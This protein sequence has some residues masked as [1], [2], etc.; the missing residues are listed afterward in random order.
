MSK[1]GSS[2]KGNDFLEWWKHHYGTDYDN[3]GNITKSGSMTDED[4]AIGK[5]LL[6]S[7]NTQQHLKSQYNQNVQTE[8]DKYNDLIDISDR[9]YDSKIENAQNE[10]D[11]SAQLLLDNYNRNTE[12]AK[13]IYDKNTEELLANYGTA[14]SALD[15]S[16]RQSQQNASITL[17]KLK[18]YLPT[19]I[20]AQGLGGLGVSESSMLKAY[21][22]YNSDMGAIESG[23]QESKSDLDANYNTNKNAYDTQYQKTRGDLDAL[24]GESQANLE[25]GLASAKSGLETAKSQASDTYKA[26][27]ADTLAKL[28]QGYDSGVFNSDKDAQ[29]N[30]L[31]DNV[32][33]EYAQMLS[34]EQG[35]N[36]ETALNAI[37]S[38]LFSNSDEMNKFVEQYRG[39]VNDQQ[40]AAL[41][42]EGTNVANTNLKNERTTNYNNARSAIENAT[43]TSRDDIMNWLKN[44]YEGKVSQE[45]YKTLET[46]AQNKASS[47]TFDFT[48]G[49]L[50][51]YLLEGKYKE[52]DAFYKNNSTVLGDVASSY[53]S[54]IDSGLQEQEEAKKKDETAKIERITSGQEAF[55]YDGGT[56]QIT[57]KLSDNANEITKN[58]DFKEQLRNKCGTSDP[59]DSSKI[60]NGT[61]FTFKSDNSGSNEFNAKDI[62]SWL[63]PT[64]WKSLIPGYNIYNAINNNANLETRTI[65]FYNG[66]WYRS[67]KKV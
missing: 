5:S 51:Q 58:N 40:L 55:Q 33:K 19:Q 34:D 11:R 12:S 65:T 43:Y 54:R 3:S 9:S 63:V 66:K 16:K 48:T 41:F 57:E 10:Y 46:L 47:N 44:T 52:A 28:K 49:T 25:S 38:A 31:V 37:R 30:L 56:Y 59:F 21:N 67:D 64:S 26:Q 36:Y 1:Y 17:D 62:A 45:D 22:N 50:E 24:Y 2:Y 27:L 7:Y 60:P 42:Q 14:Q 29:G 18:K 53:R 23:Y 61:T 35:V 39:S 15:K 20:K 6:N 8:T 4:V 13:Q 32:L